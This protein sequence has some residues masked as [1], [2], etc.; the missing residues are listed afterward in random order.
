MDGRVAEPL[1]K[2]ASSRH[3]ER[4]RELVG[5]SFGLGSV[6]HLVFAVKYEVTEFVSCVESVTFAGFLAAQEDEGLPVPVEAVGVEVLGVV[7]KRED[8]NAMCLEE[9][10]RQSGTRV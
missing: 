1:C 8:T 3:E 9:V 7:G 6:R 5:F 2:H 10:D 4:S